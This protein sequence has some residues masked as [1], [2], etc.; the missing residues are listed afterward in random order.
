LLGRKSSFGVVHDV[1]L[2]LS[3]DADAKSAGAGSSQIDPQE[4]AVN[5]RP[6]GGLSQFWVSPAI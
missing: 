1:L 2:G 6:S 5:P 3:T 4:I